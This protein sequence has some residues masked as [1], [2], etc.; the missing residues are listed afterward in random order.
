MR[1]Y[2]LLFYIVGSNW[3]Y[4]QC[5]IKGITTNPDAPLNDERPTRTNLYFD[6]RNQFCNV[7][8]ASIP[9]TQIESPS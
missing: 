6:W 7:N 9:V 3:C 1:K 8:S 5:P 4:S 2:L